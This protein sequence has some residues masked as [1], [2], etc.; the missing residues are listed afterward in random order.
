MARKRTQDFRT[1]AK[2][3]F[4]LTRMVFEQGFG[5]VLEEMGAVADGVVD[6]MDVQDATGIDLRQLA[7]LLRAFS[8]DATRNPNLRAG[9]PHLAAHFAEP[10]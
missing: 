7:K 2:T 6:D 10:L 5:A 8:Q 9:L 1:D 3:H 4:A